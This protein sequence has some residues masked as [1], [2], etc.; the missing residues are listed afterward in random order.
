MDGELASTFML[1]ADGVGDGEGDLAIADIHRMKWIKRMSGKEKVG[2]WLV[3]ECQELMRNHADSQF[4]WHMC[5]STWLF[6]LRHYPISTLLERER[7]A[8]GL[9]FLEDCVYINE[10]LGT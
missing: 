1:E 9:R 3:V 2:D 10:I 6:T 8:Q 4:L 5:T 7:A